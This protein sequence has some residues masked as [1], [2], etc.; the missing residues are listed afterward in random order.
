MALSNIFNEPRRE[1][2]ETA[3]GLTICAPFVVLD[4]YLS[5][6][7]QS[8]DRDTVWFGLYLLIVGMGLIGGAAVLALL[9]VVAHAL[10]ER[11]CNVLQ[12]RGI[13]LRPRRITER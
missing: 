7:W 6:Y 11:L 4:Y 13:H 2:T 8:H 9:T 10:G 3:V 12:D 1:I 5:V